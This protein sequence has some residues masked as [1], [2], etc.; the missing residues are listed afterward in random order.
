MEEADGYQRPVS[1]TSAMLRNALG[2]IGLGELEE[3]INGRMQ[4]T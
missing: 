3:E 1:I 2:R 4:R